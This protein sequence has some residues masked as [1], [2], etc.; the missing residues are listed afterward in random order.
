MSD[1]KITNFKVDV[2]QARLNES[3][4]QSGLFRALVIETNGNKVVLDTAFG[5][6]RGVVPDKLLKGD[7]ILARLIPGKSEPSLKIE[8]VQTPAQSLPDKLLNQLTRLSNPATS[9][10]Q[11]IKVLNHTADKTLLQ[12]NQ[13]TYAISRQPLLEKGETLLLKLSENNKVELLRINPQS[14]LKNALSNFLPRTNNAG[15]TTDLTHLQ[16]SVS[17]FL[18]LK[19]ANSS[20][21]PTSL[22]NDKPDPQ[23]KVAQ[24]FNK[25]QENMGVK[26]KN[27]LASD[28]PGLNLQKEI[29]VN[30][31]RQLLSSLSQPVAKVD[32][33]KAGTLQQI[34]KMLSLLKTATSSN[35]P[36]SLTSIASN[37]NEL[38]SAIKNSPENFKLLLRQIFESNTAEAKGK[39]PDSVLTE[40]SNTLK[41]DLLQQLEQSLSQMLTQKTSIRLN[42]EL[43]LPIQI[44]LNIPLQL[45]NE[46]T[47]L[48]LKIKQQNNNETDEEQRW[49]ISLA[50]EFALLG[51]IS[52]N[53]LLLDSKI[54]ANFW[55]EK[56]NTKQLIDSHMNQFK[57]QL[58]KS[59]FELG[60]FDC[61]I[62]KPKEQEESI[63]PMGESLVDINV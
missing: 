50:F 61:F 46:T 9:L 32:G 20:K 6:L 48:K 36:H 29:P 16:K 12:I 11:V 33:F 63:K 57:N 13:K 60:Y 17:N 41:T 38:N 7:E 53:I 47:S 4:Q 40:S 62:G 22:L 14:I 43:N 56:L 39:I 1:I 24:V 59:G 15:S 55:A 27:K 34:F 49:E 2:L 45:N 51:L 18:N 21:A 23:S 35:Q 58:Q 25:Q 19:L 10:P 28:S 37:I 52:T 8:K 26:A 3:V 42:Q 54:S 5:Q 31:I 30:T 44:N